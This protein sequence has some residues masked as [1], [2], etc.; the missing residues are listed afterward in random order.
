MKAQHRPVLSDDGHFIAI[1][2][3]THELRIIEV[4]DANN[5]SVL[6]QGSLPKIPS[7]V[8]DKLVVLRF[9]PPP[10]DDR[11]AVPWLI[12]SDGSRL[13][14]L[15]IQHL[16]NCVQDLGSNTSAFVAADYDLGGQQ[17]GRLQYADFAFS[18]EHVFALFEASG[19]ASILSTSRPHRDDIPGIKFASG[20][21]ISKSP[22]GQSA[23]LLLRSKGQDQ[24]ML[25]GSDGTTIKTQAC[26]SLPTA[27]A[28]SVVFCPSRDPVVAVYD[29]PAY[30]VKVHFFSA[31]G[32]H[33]KAL[34]ITDFGLSVGLNGVGVSQL[35]WAKSTD[36][37]II[38]VADGHKQI[39][40]RKQKLRTMS[41]E[42]VGIFTHPS[43][44]NGSKSIVWQQ[45]GEIEFALQ[46][47]EFDAVL[48]SKSSGDVALLE[49]NCDQSYLATSLADNPATVWIWQPEHPDPHTIITFGSQVRSLLWHPKL[50]NVLVIITSSKEPL[51]Y[52]WDV[53]TRPPKC[54]KIALPNTESTRFETKWLDYPID[55]RY[56]F[57]M[58]SIKA[59]EYGFLRPEDNTVVF[60]SA[61]H[62]TSL[63]LEG[64]EESSEISTPSKAAK[65]VP[66]TFDDGLW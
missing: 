48:E 33:L 63:H 32:H 45:T 19:N 17:F 54:C 38:A 26:F 60:E 15:N 4:V 8:W 25:L 61:I 5:V 2:T 20:R 49:F 58:T 12:A 43:T 9:A 30:G 18:N 56:P 66:M 29:S 7:T 40:I 6:F 14:V 51:L 41:V 42:N 34:D 52:C 24:L 13:L 65:R 11:A 62:S 23:T 64:E 57:V 46:K 53:E 27:D 3:S 22:T 39:F 50:A 28:Q 36:S 59:I 16:L 10:I 31:T 21:G 37:T 35:H 55:G 44:I 47:G 1:V